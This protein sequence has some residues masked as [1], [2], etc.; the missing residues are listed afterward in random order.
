MKNN[1]F[2][3]LSILVISLT[4]LSFSSKEIEKR[5]VQL[6]K[7]L[8]ASKYE[9]TNKEYRDFLTDLKLTKQTEKY[10][11]CLYD[12]TKWKVGKESFF[13]PY[14]KMYHWHPAYNDY[15]VVNITKEAAEIYC[16]W[17]TKKYNNSK[18]K[19]YK[20]VIFR[21]PTDLEWKRLAKPLS[22]NVFPWYGT[23]PYDYN[24]IYL[25]NI[26]SKHNESGG[27]VLTDDGGLTTV[28]VGTYKPNS[29]G[30]Y[31]VIGNVAELTKDN[32]IL[33]GSWD[34][35]ID[36]CGIDKKQTFDLPDPRVGFRIVME[37]IEN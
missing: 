35:L 6:D 12:S 1:K 29:I 9:L 30:I 36:E 10:Q 22:D 2:Y 27:T 11:K 7:S 16:E 23:F 26:K 37:I 15:P 33:G 8:Y 17:L 19:T 18:E 24:G 5:F 28:V 32:S 31:D 4:L 13:E 14:E 21:L 34:N 25:T 3:L 20:N